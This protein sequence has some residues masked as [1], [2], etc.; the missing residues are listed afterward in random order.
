MK[1]LNKKG[2]TIDVRLPKSFKN[3]WIKALRSGE[4]EQDRGHLQTNDGYCCLGV[5]CRIMHPKMNLN[6]GDISEYNFGKKKLENIKVPK[7]LKTYSE[8]NPVT[9]ILIN[10]N[11]EKNYSFK[12]IATWIEKNL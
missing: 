5:A 3:K 9:E 7:L 2:K 4:Y 1:I 11:D 10:L 8:K 6:F 12:K